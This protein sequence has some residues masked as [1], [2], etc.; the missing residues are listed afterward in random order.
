MFDFKHKGYGL[1][2]PT[3]ACAALIGGVGLGV[4]K[5]SNVS[6]G[7]IL[8]TKTKYIGQQYALNTAD[9]YCRLHNYASLAGI[10]KRKID[11]SDDYY[12]EVVIN[13]STV[14]IVNGSTEMSS[15]ASKDITVNVYH[16]E[17]DRMPLVSSIKLYRTD[18]ATFEPGFNM[19]ANDA[20]SMNEYQ[21]MSANAFRELLKSKI[22]DDM[23]ADTGDV[24]MSANASKLY[25][26]SVLK[27]YALADDTIS[28]ENDA[29]VG[30]P[31]RG[32]YIDQDGVAKP[33]DVIVR[34]NKST[35][36]DPLIL[37]PEKKGNTWQF[38]TIRKSQLKGSE[39]TTFTVTIKQTP[40][41]TITVT[42]GDGVKH[43]ESFDAKKGTTWTATVNGATGY[44]PGKLIST[45]GTV[46]GATTV[47][48]TEAT[49]KQFDFNITQ[50]EGQTIT[51][52]TGDGVKHTESFKAKYGTT[53]SATVTGTPTECSYINIDGENYPIDDYEDRASYTTDWKTYVVPDNVNYIEYYGI[54]GYHH[55]N[56]ETGGADLD[57][58]FKLNGKYVS[59]SKKFNVKSGDVIQYRVSVGYEGPYSGGEV[60]WCI[61]AL[62]SNPTYSNT[63]GNLI[64]NN[65]DTGSTF[66]SGTIMGN[67]NVSATT[68]KVEQDYL[69][70][71]TVTFKVELEAHDYDDGNHQA[72]FGYV[73]GQYSDPVSTNRIKLSFGYLQE[74]EFHTDDNVLVCA[75]YVPNHSIKN[76][77]TNKIISVYFDGFPITFSQPIDYYINYPNTISG[78]WWPDMS[79]PGCE[80]LGELKDYFRARKNITMH[81]KITNEYP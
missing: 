30:S 15:V 5:M 78:I 20:T 35:E 68:A 53:W 72:V 29:D 18:P 48:A 6:V 58:N 65:V 56:N 38:N 13:D 24:A 27:N 55:K 60:N 22:S 9:K 57:F 43:T 51:V 39:K 80:N 70:Y 71:D 7:A 77:I 2:L 54:V 66:G 40:N 64:V 34:G 31:F 50:S 46:T 61:K 62:L 21:A 3:V 28:V 19:V 67:M 26:N 12:E 49:I 25:I 44:N 45:S 42:T 23:T 14:P 59:S 32:I 11:G 8:S 73:N 63:A 47:S 81:I 16:K 10:N 41:Q 1:L 52:T 4:T 37:V 17:A 75:I 79:F 36:A 76:D 69:F 74:A 33:I